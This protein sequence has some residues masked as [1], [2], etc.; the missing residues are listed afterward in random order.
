MQWE[1]TFA[2][3]SGSNSNPIVQGHSY[4]KGRTNTKNVGAAD[5]RHTGYKNT[6]QLDSV[7]KYGSCNAAC[8]FKELT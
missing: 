5:G 7:N 6:T 2:F 1:C 8:F 4:S 3:N